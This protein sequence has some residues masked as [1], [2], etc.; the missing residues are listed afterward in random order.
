MTD[1]T[2]TMEGT[3]AHLRRFVVSAPSCASWN[4]R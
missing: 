2:A 4:V 3:I 1:P